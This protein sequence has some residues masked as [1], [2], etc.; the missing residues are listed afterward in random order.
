M[1]QRVL[2]DLLQEFHSVT[3]HP[4][5]CLAGLDT[6]KHTNTRLCVHAVASADLQLLPSAC[7]EAVAVSWEGVDVVS[8]WTPKAKPADPCNPNS[9]LH[10]PPPPRFP[11]S[12]PPSRARCKHGIQF[13]TYTG[14]S[15]PCWPLH[16]SRCGSLDC[17]LL[18]FLSVL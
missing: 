18:V 2:G 8:V 16:F 17:G 12:F 14:R 11:P 7:P 5:A 3:P 9:I 10:C 1:G 13:V 6:H 15:E 4:P